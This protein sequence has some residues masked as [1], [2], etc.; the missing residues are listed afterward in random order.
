MKK[1]IVFYFLFFI[2]LQESSLSCNGGSTK[3]KDK[4]QV[5]LQRPY[6]QQ[7]KSNQTDAQNILKTLFLEFLLVSN[8]FHKQLEAREDCRQAL[9]KIQK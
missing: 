9:K 8:Q 3:C 1:E 2:T 7:A 5:H 4:Y 6:E